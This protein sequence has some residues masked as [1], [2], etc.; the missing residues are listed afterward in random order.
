MP[1][2]KHVEI[3][4]IS[5]HE[6]ILYNNITKKHIKLGSRERNFYLYLNHHSHPFDEYLTPEQQTFLEEKFKELGFL[7]H[8]YSNLI[9]QKKRDLTRIPILFFNPERTL[10]LLSP[11]IHFLFNKIVLT[12]LGVF[13]ITGFFI[14][15]MFR[16]HWLL[17]ISMD[18]L[19]VKNLVI[20]YIMMVFTLV[21]HEFSHAI[22]C[23]FLGGKVKEIGFMLFYFQFALY[24]NVSSIY[25]FKSR[26]DKILVSLAGI[27][28]QIILVSIA[29]I[30]QYI[31]EKLSI[32][33][34]ILMYY[35]VLNIGLII[36]NLIPL[37][38]LDGYWILTY[39]T[40]ITNLRDKSFQF[41]LSSFIPK[42]KVINHSFSDFEIKVFKLYGITSTLFTLLF[43][44]NSLYFL[45]QLIGKYNG[46]T[47]I[48]V[49]IILVLMVFIHFIRTVR[50]YI[51][52]LNEKLTL[53]S[54]QTT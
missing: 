34:N 38:K 5:E 3:S 46:F 37:V 14:M 42:Y 8:D 29:V 22:T 47:S 24:C 13:V 40:G 51:L 18:S 21:I 28:S 15:G 12:F 49:L 11:F 4:E 17:N 23:H 32:H 10:N 31:L 26:K 54:S 27:I 7:Q 35:I 9:V 25:T 39:L 52:F 41:L 16:S 2:P 53:L 44:G 36:I 1:V 6:Y 33:Q 20:L 50:S 45:I 43:W 30:S 48:L 19:N